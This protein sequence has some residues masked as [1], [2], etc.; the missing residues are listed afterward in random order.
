MSIMQKIMATVVQFMPDKDADP[1]THK[2]GYVGQALNRVDGE[3]KVKGEARFSAEYPLENMA[4]AALVYSTVAKGKITLL[5]T[6]QAE[7]SN[8]V[9]AV[10]TYKNAPKMQDP[11]VF[12]AGGE[13]TGSAGSSLPIMQD[14]NIYW[15]GQPIAIVVAE[16]LEQA[17]H[18]AAL[19]TVD[20]KIETPSVSFDALKADAKTP[21]DILGEPPK[22][23]IGTA[24][25]T[26]AQSVL[27][28]DQVYHTPRYN[29]NAIEPHATIAVWH[30][31][32]S[33]TVF[34]P[35]Q[36][37]YGVK[38]TLAEIFS[39]KPDNVRVI[40]PF[41]GGG[42]GGKGSLWTN[43]ALCVMAAKIIKR[44]VKLVVSREGV[45][46]IVGGRT[47]SEQRVALSVNKANKLTAL[48]HTGTTAMT[49]HNY[50]PEQFSFPARNLYAAENIYLH[51]KF[52]R[53]DTVANSFMRAP[54]ESIGTFALESAIDEL[55]HTLQIDPIELR[56]LNEPA[57]DP[58]KG[59]EF[60]SRHLLEA[61]QRGAEKFGWQNHNPE[62]RSQR[63]GKWLIGQGVA[64]AYYPTYRFPASARVRICADGTAVV[65]ASAHE[66][67]MGT[68][69]VQIQHAAQRLGLPLDKVSFQYGDSDLPES[70]VA[71]GS[72]Q[73]VSIIASVTAAAE[74]A[75]K[76]LFALAGHHADSPLFSLKYEQIEARANGLY[77]KDDSSQGETYTSILNRFALDYVEAEAASEMPIEIEKYSIHSYGAQ[78][79]EVRVNEETGETRVSRWLGSFDCGRILNPKTAI[80][81]FRGGI[82]MGIGMALM[83]ETLFDERK[84]RIMNPSLAEYHVP[85]NLD[86]PHIDIIYND[87][88]DE[89]TPLG[90]H[91][92]GEI[93]IT[94]AAAAIANAIFNATG[95]RVRDL[96]ITLDKLL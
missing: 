84:G 22:I 33:L 16:T 66:M 82:V 83:E 34:D 67:G 64:S 58:T 37:V 17:E 24:E 85:V 38:R 30:D 80:S 70:P 79:C 13:S 60:S 3:L 45:F 57:K 91:G 32:D 19:I 14:E 95:K 63:D 7:Q 76:K 78:F 71:G 21:D 93:G 8:G 94:G 90:A 51:Q 69:T 44:P 73:T 39:L 40:A 46:R 43:T 68:A 5:D 42:F 15:N 29:H 4:Q 88:A 56:R 92:I 36:N 9:I 59:T 26:L 35:S 87:I 47:L 12:K 50:F 10:I 28:I 81:Q 55:A 1:L 31:D 49:A 61:Y 89:H 72:N 96:P 18:A 74:K 75:H 62:P 25:K 6:R 27:Q 20:Y 52:V 53:M 86:V 54:G 65:S 2:E 41:V 77:S 11:P 23:E 48:I